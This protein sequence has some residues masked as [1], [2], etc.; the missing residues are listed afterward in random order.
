MRLFLTIVLLLAPM[1]IQAKSAFIEPYVGLAKTEVRLGDLVDVG[2]GFFLGV[3]SGA[4]FGRFFFGGD[5]HTGGPYTFGAPL[6]RGEWNHTMIGGGLGADYGVARFWFGYY[7][8]GEFEDTVNNFKL[9]TTTYKL[10]VALFVAKRIRASLDFLFYDVT[11]Y[12][13]FGTEL[14]DP[15]Y[16]VESVHV[17]LSLPFNF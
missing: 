5:Y 12:E 7:P 6:Q 10:S 9:K 13:S 2:D 17:S 3:K 1:S 14:P 11:K 15:G 8:D 4:Y 16:K